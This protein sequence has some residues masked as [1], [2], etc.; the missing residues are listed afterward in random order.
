MM[1]A[2]TDERGGVVQ[3]HPGMEY[4]KLATMCNKLL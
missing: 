2:G 4:T 1:V 3:S